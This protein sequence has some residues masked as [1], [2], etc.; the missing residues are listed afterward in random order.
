MKNVQI[1]F[2]EDL[3]IMI[4]RMAE[5]SR[6]TRSAVIREAVRAWLRQR[7]IN[8]FEELWISKLQDRP[9]DMND[10]EGWAA[11]EKWGDE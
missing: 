4:D 11:A 5:D 9:N 7:E 3:L 8:A 1:S 6:K 2:D 10:A